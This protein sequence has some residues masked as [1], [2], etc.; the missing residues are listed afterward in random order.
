LKIIDIT[1]TIRENMPVFK[2]KADKKPLI[3]IANGY[4]K[5]GIHETRIDLDLHSGTHLDAPMHVI[6]NGKSVDQ[7]DLSRLI[8]PCRLLDF[9]DVTDCIRREDLESRAFDASE[10]ILLKTR[11][12]FE[13]RYVDDFIY[14]DPSGAEYL[15][16][17]GVPGVGIDALRIERQIKRLETH[18]ILF[19]SGIIVLEGLRLKDAA[20]GVYQLY[21]LPMKIKGVEASPVRAILIDERW[22]E[23]LQSETE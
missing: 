20:E 7:I 17:R 6:T 9:T 5:G 3:W 21:A 18:R 1:M 2:N 8:A 4:Q 10:F 13:E 19:E 23:A 14:L 15:K 11:N 16:E 22:V 12:S